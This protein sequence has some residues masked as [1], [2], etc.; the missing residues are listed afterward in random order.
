MD[1]ISPT[2][3][4]FESIVSL[5]LE[6]VTCAFAVFGTLSCDDGDN[7]DAGEKFQ[8]L[9]LAYEEVL[10]T[11][12]DRKLRGLNDIHQQLV[13]IAT[14]YP[15]ADVTAKILSSDIVGINL[16]RVERAIQKI[17]PD[18]NKHTETVVTDM[19]S[20]YEVMEAPYN[21]LIVQIAS[22]PHV[23][24]NLPIE[25]KQHRKRGAGGVHQTTTSNTSA[26]C[27]A[28]A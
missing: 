5:L 4:S 11:K 3:I 1:L 28:K 22:V 6:L 16:S 15:D 20:S 9:V 17:D 8:E 7:A 12:G 19:S 25:V 10:E 13:E 21:D 27:E 2:F 18:F 23:P 26:N 14:I 24:K